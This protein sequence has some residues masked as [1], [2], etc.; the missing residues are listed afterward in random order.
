LDGTEREKAE[1]KTKLP[2]LEVRWVTRNCLFFKSYRD[3]ERDEE[4]S[5]D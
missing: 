5:S 2:W 3:T 4:H 1:N